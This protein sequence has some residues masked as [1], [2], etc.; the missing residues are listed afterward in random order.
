MICGMVTYKSIIG[1]HTQLKSRLC[2]GFKY[3]LPLFIRVSEVFVF[4]LRMRHV[5][6]DRFEKR[7]QRGGGI[8]SR[9]PHD[10]ISGFRNSH[11]QEWSKS[12]AHNAGQSV[13]WVFLYQT[14][15]P[16]NGVK[17]PLQ[18]SLMGEFFIWN[19]RV[20]VWLVLCVCDWDHSWVGE[21]QNL[22]R[23]HVEL[24]MQYHFLSVVSFQNVQMERVTF[25]S[26]KQT[27][28]RHV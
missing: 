24:S 7:P 20:I 14:I 10:V 11:T 6:F 23:H 5:P 25:S 9:V 15:S 18:I 22:W 1:F 28:V 3:R 2:Q 27:Q 13:I 12:Q 16:P 4:H 8:A 17:I 19:L 21:S 26:G